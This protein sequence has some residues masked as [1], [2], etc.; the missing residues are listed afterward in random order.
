MVAASE[1]TNEPQLARFL[2]I[3]TAQGQFIMSG[4]PLSSKEMYYLVL[5]I[6]VSGRGSGAQLF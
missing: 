2:C 6:A 3:K 4:F 5:G 1:E